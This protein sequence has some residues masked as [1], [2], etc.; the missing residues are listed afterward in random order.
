MLH[1]T[2]FAR[3]F[4]FLGDFARHYGLFEACGSTMPFSVGPTPAATGSCCC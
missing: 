3:H 1:E 4:E 2:R